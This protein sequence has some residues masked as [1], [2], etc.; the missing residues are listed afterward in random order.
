MAQGN[1]ITVTGIVLEE[2][3]TIS[4]GEV[5]RSCDVT[6]EY[7]I[8]L[9]DEG[10]LEPLG[11]QPAEWQFPVAAVP[12]IHVAMRLQQDMALNLP[13]VALALDLLDEMQALRSR[14][15]VLERLLRG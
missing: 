14:V 8:A 2:A 6:A 9:V 7:V 13:G 1:E 5:C 15:R 12:R 10:L 3:Q 11:R 4:L